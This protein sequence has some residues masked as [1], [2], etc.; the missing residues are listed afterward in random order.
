MLTKIEK[1]DQR[2]PGLAAR[3]RTWFDQGI[4]V[5][6]IVDLLRE[7]YGV[8]VPKSTV[9][10]FRAWRWVPDREA[11]NRAH[12]KLQAALELSRELEMKDSPETPTASLQTK[13]HMLL[14]PDIGA[15]LKSALARSI[16]TA[17]G[18]RRLRNGRRA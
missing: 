11:L 5:L 16:R 9:G 8:S 15:Y 4:S 12:A 14:Y 10:N 2:F 3:V 13:V 7:H 18:S 1:L 17:T 6:K